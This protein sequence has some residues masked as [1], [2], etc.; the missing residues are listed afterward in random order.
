MGLL[1]EVFWGMGDGRGVSELV[2]RGGEIGGEVITSDSVLLTTSKE[3][4]EE[5]TLG[6]PRLIAASSKASSAASSGGVIFSRS[7]RTCPLLT[8]TPGSFNS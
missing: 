2:G 7:E 6:M 4:D 8:L 1:S 5:G 3:E